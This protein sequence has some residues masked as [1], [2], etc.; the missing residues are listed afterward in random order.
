MNDYTIKN[1]SFQLIRNCKRFIITAKD[2]NSMNKTIS[3]I[4]KARKKK[5][6]VVSLSSKASV[7]ATN[8]LFVIFVLTL[9][10][11]GLHELALL[12]TA[13]RLALRGTK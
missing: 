1:N 6:E 12:V 10:A 2:E 3:G 9:F 11:T 4:I 7:D 5:L 8:V 13:G